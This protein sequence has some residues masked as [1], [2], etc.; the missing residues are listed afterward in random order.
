ME[1]QQLFISLLSKHFRMLGKYLRI[2]EQSEISC[3]DENS[4]WLD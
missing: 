3:R 2:N 1:I 4:T